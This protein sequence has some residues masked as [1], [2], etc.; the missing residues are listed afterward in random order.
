VTENRPKSVVVAVA[1]DEEGE[2]EETMLN[3]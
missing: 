3:C 2:E 1:G